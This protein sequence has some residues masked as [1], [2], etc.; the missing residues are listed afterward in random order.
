MSIC[1][2]EPLIY[3]EMTT[4]NMPGVDQCLMV[5]LFDG[6][7]SWPLMP[8][9]LQLLASLCGSAFDLLLRHISVTTL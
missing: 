6:K 3:R 8:V 1:S 4:Q 9:L 2:A 5:P 7:H